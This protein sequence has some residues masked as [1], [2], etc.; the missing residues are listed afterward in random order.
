MSG[1]AGLKS[2]FSAGQPET[3]SIVKEDRELGGRDDQDH[4][5]SDGDGEFDEA[6]PAMTDGLHNW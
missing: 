1:E 6:L 4:K 5:Q 2:T 3:I